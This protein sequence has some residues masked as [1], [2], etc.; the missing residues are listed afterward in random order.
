M[1]SS[2]TRILLTIDMGV[3]TPVFTGGITR[4][5]A[6]Y[7]DKGSFHSFLDI[8]VPRTIF[9]SPIPTILCASNFKSDITFMLSESRRILRHR[10]AIP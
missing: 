9:I 1:K 3:D 2:T 10:L 8:V 5:Q 4:L 7:L 6:R